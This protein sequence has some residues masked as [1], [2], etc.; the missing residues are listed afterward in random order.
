MLRLTGEALEGQPIE[1]DIDEIENV[2]PSDGVL[3]VGEGVF[4]TAVKIESIKVCPTPR[5]MDGL[6]G[7]A[8]EQALQIL[9][10]C[11]E[12]LQGITQPA[13]NA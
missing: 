8:Q 9:N 5:A 13:T 11:V 12:K 2:F 3:C 10:E 6:T 7:T 4:Q 1:F